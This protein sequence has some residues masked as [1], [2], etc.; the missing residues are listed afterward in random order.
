[1]YCIELQHDVWNG[2]TEYM[3]G[4]MYMTLYWALCMTHEYSK[5]F[6]ETT[7]AKQAHLL[8][9]FLQFA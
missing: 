8:S 3:E 4:L 7:D 1:M 2:I 9:N 6:G 5:R